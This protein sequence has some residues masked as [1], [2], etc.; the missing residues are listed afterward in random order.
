MYYFLI[1]PASG[2]GRGHS[3]WNTVQSELDRLQIPYTHFLLTGPGEARA[4]ARALSESPAPCTLVVVGGDG[5]INETL[6]GLTTFKNI[7]FAC[8]PTGSGNDFV[9]GLNLPTD[10]LKALHAILKPRQIQKINIGV[11]HCFAG[12]S[13]AGSFSYAVSSGIGFDAA[14]CDSVLSSRFKT[15]LNRFHS[16]KLIYLVTALWRLFTMRRQPLEVSVDGGPV[17]TYQ[18]VYF[19]AAMNLRYEGGGFCFCPEALPDDDRIDLLIAHGIPRWQVLYLLPLALKGKHVG[20][21]GI[22]IIRCQSVSLQ[23][24][25]PLCVHTDGE[26]PGF[27]D[28]VTFSLRKEK[29]AVIR[30]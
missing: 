20:H 12:S 5:T 8:I 17:Q 26:I 9:R 15:L 19:A 25:E 21:P 27:Y 6:N 10:P 28:R 14:V 7:T 4:L 18:K 24:P 3:V 22:E 1:N 30:K 13:S 29:L 2:S 16:G 23:S 11:T